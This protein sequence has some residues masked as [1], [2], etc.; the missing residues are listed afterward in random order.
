MIRRG[1]K[2]Q[3]LQ[4]PP[5]L[6][7]IVYKLKKNDY[8]FNHNLT[9][10]EKFGEMTEWLIVAALMTAEPKGQSGV[11]IPL[12]HSLL[13]AYRRGRIRPLTVYVATKRYKF[14]FL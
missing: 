10:F 5:F 3:V 8:Y 12:S 9:F 1:S 7:L 13:S 2:V 14:L 4:G 6:N 11:R